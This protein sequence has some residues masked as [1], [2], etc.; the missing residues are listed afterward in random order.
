VSVETAIGDLTPL[1]S[2]L[3][4][5]EDSA[6]GWRKTVIADAESLAQQADE[7]GDVELADAFREVALNLTAN[8]PILRNSRQLPTG[9]GRSNDPLRQ[10]ME[11]PQLIALAQH[12]TRS[13]MASDLGRYLFA[14]TFGR[15]RC[16]PAKK[17]DYFASLAP[18][19]R[20]WDRGIFSDRFRVQLA[21]GPSTTIVSHIAKDGHYF[22]HPDPAQCRSLTVREAARLQTFPDDYLF[23]GHRTQQY[24]QVGN[25]VPPYLARQIANLLFRV[26]DGKASASRP[27]LTSSQLD[28]VVGA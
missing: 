8:A 11:R 12:E 28:A 4:R 15:L 7:A 27:V 16:R 25:A 5:T 17:G 9:Y 20:S 26:L 13:H 14:A 2:G 10:W 3:S 6:P 24:V 18:D 19:H 22:I 21:D 23:L 1:R